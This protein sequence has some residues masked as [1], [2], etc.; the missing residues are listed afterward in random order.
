MTTRL[1]K[2]ITRTGD[3]GQTRLGDGTS[4]PKNSPRIDSLGE[5]DE[6]NSAIGLLLCED[7]AEP[8]RNVLLRI[9]NDLFTLGGEISLPNQRLMDEGHT[10]HLEQV[11]SDLNA[12]LPALK[13][14][15]LP[16]G[17]R[18]GALA[19]LCRAICRRAERSLFRLADTEAVNELSYRYLN[20]LSDLLFILGRSINRAQG[21]T[22]TGWKKPKIESGTKD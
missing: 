13:E 5:I 15:I 11:A 18:A 17:T 19:H 20:R 4:T 12:Q 22:E 2:I 3:Q 8:L 9:Q 16:G 21:Q 1:S 6:L 14:F 7:L 10:R